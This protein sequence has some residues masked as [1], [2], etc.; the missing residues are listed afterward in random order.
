DH[1][2]LY[3]FGEQGVTVAPPC[4]QVVVT[5]APGTP[6]SFTLQCTPRY[7]PGFEPDTTGSFE[8]EFAQV[9]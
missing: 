8:G 1:E 9:P 5:D 2:S 4:L 6:V 7:G 3:P